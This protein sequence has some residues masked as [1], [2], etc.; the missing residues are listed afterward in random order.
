MGAV[1]GRRLLDA[2]LLA[3]LVGAAALCLATGLPLVGVLAVVI[4]AVAVEYVATS[5]ATRRVLEGTDWRDDAIPPAVEAAVADLAA[6]MG[7]DRPRIRIDPDG[8]AGVNVLRDDTGAV[9]LLSGSLPDDLSEGALRGIVAH[10]LA[11]VALDHLRRLPVRE[12]SAHVVGFAVLWAVVLADLWLPTAAVVGVTYLAAAAARTNP[13]NALFYV[14]GSFGAVLVMRTV[15]TY[16]ERLEEC[17]ADD[18]AVAH[19]SADAFCTGLAGVGTAAGPDLGG[20]DAVAGSHPLSDQR[21]FP[22][23]FTAAHPT[24]EYRLARHGFSLDEKGVV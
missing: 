14:G 7:I 17:R 3:A 23:R 1:W 12:A 8:D 9:L 24:V 4:G 11:H 22:E 2:C 6:A 19:T 18:L 21:G 16:A 5:A 15:A 20:Y 13:V 10:E